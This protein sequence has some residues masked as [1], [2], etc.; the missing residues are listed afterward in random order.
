MELPVDGVRREAVAYYPSDAVSLPRPLIL[1]FHGHGGSTRSAVLS[2]GYHLL[3]PETIVVYMQGLPTPI[4][5]SDPQGKEPGWQISIALTPPPK[6]K[7]FFLQ[8]CL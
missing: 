2:F 1:V 4:M 3:W 8:G 5:V 6:R 7:P